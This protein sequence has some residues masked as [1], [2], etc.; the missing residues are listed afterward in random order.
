LCGEENY[1]TTKPQSRTQKAQIFFWALV[2]HFQLLCAECDF[3]G[4]C[5]ERDFLFRLINFRA[6]RFCPGRRENRV[7][8]GEKIGHDVRHPKD[9]L[10]G[11]LKTN[12]F[13]EP[14]LHR[15]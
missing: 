2:S 10:R 13:H 6:E 4:F 3:L 11:L 15:K 14:T 5:G 8:G 7:A 9:K 1:S 12:P